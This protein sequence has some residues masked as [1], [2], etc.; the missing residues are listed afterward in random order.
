MKGLL[1]VPA[2]IF[3]LTFLSM[4]A[5]LAADTAA[6]SGEVATPG[7]QAGQPTPAEALA[8]EVRAIA[9]YRMMSHAKKE[10]RIANAVRIATVSATAYKDP[11]EIVNIALELAAAAASAAPPFKDAIVHAVLFTPSVAGIDGASGQIQAAVDHAAAQAAEAENAAEAK[12]VGNPVKAGTVETAPA[13]VENTPK[14]AAVETAAAPE[15]QAPP[16]PPEKVTVIQPAETVAPPP[17][18]ENG[19]KAS[20]A[21]NGAVQDR[22]TPWTLPKIDLG[23]NASLHFTADLNA[24]YDDNIFLLNKDKVGDEILSATPGAIF[25]FG[26]NS[27]ANGSLSYQ[28]SFQHYIQ[29]RS[30]DQQLGTGAG[31][32]GYS[33]ERLDLKTN[34]DYVQSAQNQEGFF[35]PGQKVVVRRN[36]LDLG[37]SQ[38]VHFTEK[39][40]AGVGESYSDT[41]YLTP[42]LGLVDNHSSSFPLNLYYSVRPKVDLSAGFTQSEIKTPGNGPGSLQVN[43]YY[44][45]GA[46]GDFTP[47]LTGGLS[48]GYTT[49]AVTQSK[50]TSIF[51]F[52]ANLAYDLSPKTNL[53]LTA[54]RNF[55]AGAQGEQTKSTSFAFTASTVFSPRWQG[56]AGLSYQNLGYPANRTDN[57]LAGTVA[58]TYIFSTKVNLTLS[59]SLNN[60][61]ST[62]S[63]AEYLDNILSL[64]VGLKY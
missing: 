60:N 61:Y 36:Q 22:S 24:R 59:Y 5:G 20:T 26:Q 45:V 58:A 44:N 29:K 14:V 15:S 64:S 50:S 40:S 49:S 34:A 62:V 57:N 8:A 48:V 56:S 47:K 19:T 43:R 38:E 1:R 16:A 17:N 23:R 42:G 52:N 2:L 46:R 55:G 41:H 11:A 3:F 53:G 28:E 13:A 4:Q 39:T 33:N 32:F 30:S 9:N 7:N 18:I 10:K 51:A 27:L 6:S 35:I 12:P 21:E 54:S 37:S 25:Q 63:T 31:D